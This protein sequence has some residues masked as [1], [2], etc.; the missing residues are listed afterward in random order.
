[1][2]LSSTS[3][4]SSSPFISTTGTSTTSSNI[5]SSSSD[6]ACKSNSF[7]LRHATAVGLCLAV[8]NGDIGV[9]RCVAAK[10]LAA[11]AKAGSSEQVFTVRKSRGGQYEIVSLKYQKCV[12]VVREGT[13]THT[14]L[15][16]CSSGGSSSVQSSSFFLPVSSLVRSKLLYN[17]LSSLPPSPNS[18]ASLCVSLVNKRL[19]TSECNSS[20]SSRGSSSRISPASVTGSSQWWFVP[21]Y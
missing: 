17:L 13:K 11:N 5:S 18:S 3:S 4:G 16:N 19:V 2:F 20:T 14:L 10:R 12:S 6:T 1:M 21:V 7:L 15:T 9:S 8:V